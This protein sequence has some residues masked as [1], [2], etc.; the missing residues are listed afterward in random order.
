MGLTIEVLADHA[1]PEMAEAISGAN[2]RDFH[3][4]GVRPGR[5]F[6][7]S[8]F[9]DLRTATA[10]DACPRC[11]SGALEIFRGIEVGQIFY[12]GQKYSKAMGAHFLDAD[13]KEHAMEM[14]CYGIGITRLLAA[15]IEQN[16]D[17]NGIIWP[18]SIAPFSV[19]LLPLNYK[20]EAIRDVTD[21]LDAELR[22]R[23]YEVLLD[24]RDE[25][26]GVKFKDADLVGIPLRV[27]IGAKGLA[28]GNVELRLR[29]E[30][31]N[32]EITVDDALERIVATLIENG[33]T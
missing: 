10:G 25:R 32:T 14:G 22:D 8:R 19:L 23:G 7:P 26:P 20:D 16:H 18:F 27:T 29:R 17:E 4:S 5:D 1:I 30:G 9:A 12:L 3:L 24:D 2:E 28:K 21:R 13:G 31:A 33:A 15:A 6:V 11:E